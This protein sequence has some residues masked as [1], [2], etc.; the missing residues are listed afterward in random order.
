MASLSN[1]L[2]DIAD[3]Y[4]QLTL[5]DE[6]SSGLEMDALVDEGMAILWIYIGQLRVGSLLKNFLILCL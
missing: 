5:E 6:A 3:Q 4:D 2:S 1:P